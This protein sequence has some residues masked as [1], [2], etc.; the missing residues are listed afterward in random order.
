MEHIRNW[1]E[2]DTIA[3]LRSCAQSACESKQVSLL[4]TSQARKKDPVLV[5]GCKPCAAELFASIFHLFGAA[6]AYAISSFKRRKIIMFKKQQTSPHSAPHF[7]FSNWNTL[8]RLPILHES[9]WL[10]S[11]V[12]KDEYDWNAKAHC[13]L[14]AFDLLPW[15]FHWPT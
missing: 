3:L 4:Q 10:S 5:N 11:A 9:V 14:L 8:L 2:D 6:A 15:T 13:I 12:A 7:L 1:M